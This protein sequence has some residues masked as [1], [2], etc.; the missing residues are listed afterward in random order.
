MSR[1]ATALVL[2]AGVFMIVP[3]AHLASAIFEMPT[4]PPP[5]S[6]APPAIREAPPA[7]P[8]D[9][10]HDQAV[11]ANPAA[12][13][14]SRTILPWDVLRLTGELDS[15]SWTVDLTSAQ[16]ESAATLTIAYKAAVVVAPESS[17]LRVFVNDHAAIESPIAAP[18]DVGHLSVQLTPGLLH[19]GSNL[20]RIEASERHRTDCSI[21]STYE[22]WT[23]I[24][25]A[26]SALHFA[27][28]DAPRRIKDIGASSVDQ[29]GF[30]NL[31]IVAPALGRTALT[32][33]VIMF[34][35][36]AA[37]LIGEPNQTVTVS[38]AASGPG[39]QGVLTAAIG[40]A[41]DLRAVMPSLPN[42]AANKPVA[43]FVDDPHL[44]SVLVLSGPTGEAVSK[45]VDSAI[46]SGGAAL[47]P[48]PKS[49]AT[50]RW[51]APDAPLMVGAGHVQ[52]S[53]LGV[54]TQ[55]FSGRVFSAQFL[56]GI[57]SDF[58]AS[59]YAQATIL[60]DAAY[61]AE[62]LPGSHLDVYVND[63]IATTTPVTT[64]G[65]AILRHLPIRVLMTHF[66]PG[67]NLIRFEAQLLTEA[68]RVCPTGGG[69]SQSSRFVL[70]DSSE[71]VMPE[72]ARIGR[73][74]DLASLAGRGFPY[75]GSDGST[76][77]VVDSADA[78]AV[79]AAATLLAKLAVA[80]GRVMP[81]DMASATTVGQRNAIFVATPAQTP[82]EVLNQVGLDLSIRAA[83][84][85][86]AKMSAEI[87]RG[88]GD[89]SVQTPP[90]DAGFA[91]SDE[92]D[93]QATFDRWRRQLADGGGWRGNV[94]SLQDWLQRT[95][96]LSAG[97]LRFLPSADAAFQPAGDS[98][99]LL[100]QATNPAGDAA[101][102]LLTAPSSSLLREGAKALT[103]QRQWS[104]IAGH[105]VSYDGKTGTL[106]TQAVTTSS[107]LPTQPFSIAN[108]RLIGA[109]WLSEN[110]FAYSVLLLAACLLLG[111]A[112]ARLVS[113]I[114]RQV[115]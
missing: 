99:I 14:A 68:D 37:V 72:Y 29:F 58:Y 49:I 88:A 57:P 51:F 47:P 28:N 50:N 107:F 8:S 56:V 59:N 13:G 76:A 7:K 94:S 112:T 89:V 84:T 35:E 46:S 109:N 92:L 62:V 105:I 15:R 90:A 10:A 25:N 19:P 17:K 64:Y 44:G 87:A 23:D 6:H 83:W 2:A 78:D 12:G 24:Y 106:R 4:E 110:I 69:A 16:A 98:A 71:F 53:D 74:P 39:G 104:S 80:R 81:I 38:K 41:E 54:H 66:K 21:A 75:D 20:I 3:P 103:A 67:A 85:G 82:D 97:T 18:E 61:S 96:E 63:H 1:M 114:G 95:F 5:A 26:G 42:D 36:G 77:L 91:K 113:R 65:G 32:R 86:P 27:A 115:P 31:R 73:L 9:A 101:W 30:A 33:S 111:L 102:T 79:S 45:A 11:V 22:L 40:T 100:A 52:F 70:F 93:T 108:L 48:Y 55:E 60:L 34:A 43:A